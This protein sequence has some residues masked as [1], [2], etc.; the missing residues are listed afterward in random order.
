MAYERGIGRLFIRCCADRCS[1]FAC[2]ARVPRSYPDIL[3][4]EVSD[5]AR[6]TQVCRLPVYF[7][8]SLDSAPR[9]V[10]SKQP[11]FVTSSL[12]PQ[13]TADMRLRNWI[14]CQRAES[15]AAQ[16]SRLNG[17]SS[18]KGWA[19]FRLP[20]LTCGRFMPEV[21]MSRLRRKPR[22][23]NGLKVASIAPTHRPCNAHR[24]VAVEPVVRIHLSFTP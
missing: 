13:A 14:A 18:K 3:R 6:V 7:R 2:S 10:V 9:S 11:I 17:F 19:A 21:S 20:L 23:Q 24:G 22:D 4:I 15:I 1:F 5:F 8:L 16:A 12:G